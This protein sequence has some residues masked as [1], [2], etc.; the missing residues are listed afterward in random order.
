MIKDKLRQ[1]RE[2]RGLSQAK[3]AE[4]LGVS[5]AAYSTYEMGTR[6]ISSDKVVKLAKFYN[7]TTDY[8]YGVDDSSSLDIDVNELSIIKK[9]R[10]LDG[11]GKRMVDSALE[12][13]Y[14]RC[15]ATPAQEDQAA[16]YKI[17]IRH[18]TYKV[19]AGTGF[20]LGEGDSWDKVEVPDTAETRKA[21]FAITIKGRSMEPVYYDGDIVLVK[22]QAA[23]D[24]GEVGIFIINGSGYI[25][26][27]GGDRLISVNAEYEDIFFADNDDIRCVGKVIGRV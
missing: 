22:E 19:S 23:V 25:K 17:S 27:Y 3:I 1:L 5:P 2:Q 4:M 24:V 13:E 20:E 21:D 18:S 9:Y 15:T 12:I 7:V 14:E 26:R 16:E 6:D 8:L 10:T 11:Y